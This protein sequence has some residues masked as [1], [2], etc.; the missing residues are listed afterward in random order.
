MMIL[1]MKPWLHGVSTSVQVDLV[2]L[3]DFAFD[4]VDDNDYDFD[5]EE[6]QE[7]T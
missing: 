4:D 3:D 1:M 2:H 7:K 6:P 5:H